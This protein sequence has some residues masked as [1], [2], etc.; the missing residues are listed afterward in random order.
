MGRTLWLAIENKG[1][2]TECI[3]GRFIFARD[4]ILI[5]VCAVFVGRQKLEKFAYLP[6]VPECV[7]FALLSHFS[8]YF[9]TCPYLCFPLASPHIAGHFEPKW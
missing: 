9:C 2:K 6:G 7:V 4:K 5:S 3:V 1:A 8:V